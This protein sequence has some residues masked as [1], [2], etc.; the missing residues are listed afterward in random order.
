M[1]S[2]PPDEA[3]YPL[4]HRF[5][6]R[7]LPALLLYVLAL[8]AALTLTAS[9]VME[10]IYL[11][12]AEQR[13]LAIAH[14]AE[15][16]A[17]RAWR[18]LLAA[19][20]DGGA[21]NDALQGALDNALRGE[22]RELRLDKLKIY[23]TRRRVLY[24][25]LHADIGKT[26]N[27]DTLRRVLSSGTGGVV[28]KVET[29]GPQYELYVPVRASD[30]DLVFELYEP[31]ARL[32]A[33]LW[34]NGTAIA[35]TGLLALVPLLWALGRLV[36][37]AQNELDRRAANL[38][39][40]RQRLETFVSRHAAQAARVSSPGGVSERV[41]ATVLYSDVRGFTR[42]AEGQSPEAVVAFLNRVVSLHV[43]A[44][45]AEGGDVDKLIGDAV[46]AWFA[47][48]DAPAQAARAAARVQRTLAAEADLPLGCGIGIHS[49]PV[50]LG[51]VGRGEVGR[52]EVRRGE[53]GGG[54]RVDFTL[55]G[56]T[57]NVA[58]RLCSAAAA[59]EVVAD[60]E[61]AP[62]G[63]TALG[64]DSLTLKGRSEPVTVRRWRLAA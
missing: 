25:P 49:G 53:G 2:A 19:A 52:G 8:G 23:D 34:R 62:P 47:G 61:L 60:P 44:V 59:G 42:F 16:N 21:L 30:Q 15:D 12:W 10:A 22:L 27:G 4:R 45:E 18:A 40:V 57:V 24:S 7:I 13:A 64:V 29:Q 54:V 11:D 32:D 3:P 20:R 5:R 43:Q 9:S 33:L 51:E 26:E 50:I 35:A 14:A 36:G 1:N 58:A 41:E 31:I 56:D 39:S 55:I 37:R 28:K 38:R 46:L 63:L 6:R 17:P 48:A